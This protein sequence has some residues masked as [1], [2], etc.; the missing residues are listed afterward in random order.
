MIE[1]LLTD[2]IADIM[3]YPEPVRNMFVACI[4]IQPDL[5][6]QAGYGAMQIP[7]LADRF[8]DNVIEAL[9]E[10][11]KHPVLFYL[12]VR[13]ITLDWQPAKYVYERLSLG[14]GLD[15]KDALAHVMSICNLFNADMVKPHLNGE[16]NGNSTKGVNPNPR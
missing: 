1:Q 6:P 2:Q 13:A 4:G 7:T 9:I 11:G 14:F 12:A 8:P 16:T 10:D 3:A 15:Y 5:D